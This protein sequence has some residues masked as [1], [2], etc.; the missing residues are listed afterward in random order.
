MMVRSSHLRLMAV[1]ISALFLSVVTADHQI[2]Y[3]RNLRAVPTLLKRSNV[4][5]NVLIPPR[6]LQ[7]EE[8]DSVSED[9]VS[10]DSLDSVSEDSVS[11][12]SLDSVS[13]D[14]LDSVSADSASGDGIGGG[15]GAA[16]LEA[17]SVDCGMNM[18][19]WA[20][21]VGAMV[22]S[23]VSSVFGFMM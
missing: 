3:R 7:D 9:S 8:E 11:E 19:C 15:V 1:C 17:L 5:Y 4:N 22:R 12:D 6:Q 10:E 20:G 18:G 13:E 21:E 23:L 14:S 2:E 16:V